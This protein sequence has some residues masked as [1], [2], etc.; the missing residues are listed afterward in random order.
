[1]FVLG[2]VCYLVFLL[3]CVKKKG[4]EIV[5]NEIVFVEEEDKIMFLLFNDEEV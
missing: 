5:S 4:Q 2:V 1:M 3:L